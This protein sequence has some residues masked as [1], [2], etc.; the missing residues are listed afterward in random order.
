[1]SCVVVRQTELQERVPAMELRPWNLFHLGLVLLVLRH[2]RQPIQKDGGENIKHNEGEANAKVSP[3]VRV[4]DGEARQEGIGA[5][6]RLA[7]IRRIVFRIQGENSLGKRAESAVL[8]RAAVDQKSASATDVR[9]KILSTGLVVQ[10]VL[11]RLPP[12]P[13]LLHRFCLFLTRFGNEKPSTRVDGIDMSRREF[14]LLPLARSPR[15][16]IEH[17]IM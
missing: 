1:M 4:V 9:I 15:T 11:Q 14:L 13:I 17:H 7:A 2:S 5:T 8:S 6:W 12:I 16:H 10:I 3:S